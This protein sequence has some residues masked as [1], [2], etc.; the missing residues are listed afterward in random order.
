LASS[1]ILS[2]RALTWLLAVGFGLSSCGGKTS[3]PSP[4]NSCNDNG[5]IHSN[6][7]SWTCS[8]SCD[9]CSCKAGRIDRA[10][11]ACIP[12]GPEGG[13][14]S[15][16]ESDSNISPEAVAGDDASASEV[17]AS[18]FDSPVLESGTEAGTP[19]AGRCLTASCNGACVDEQTDPDNCG[20]CG[21]MCPAGEI[22]Q[23][24]TCGN[25]PSCAPGGLGMTNC[26][27]GTQSCCASL[28]VPGGTYYR[29]YDEVFDAGRT[30]YSTAADGGPVDEADLATISGFRL[31][32]YEV[33]VGRFRQFVGAWS[34]G[35][36]PA[37]GS[38]KHAYLSGGQGLV[39]IGNDAAATYEPGWLVEDNSSIAPTDNN[40]TCDSS[41]TW[42]SP[43]GINEN[44]PINCV[45]WFEAYA[46][47]IWDGGFLPSGSPRLREGISSESIHG[48]PHPPAP[49]SRPPS[50]TRSTTAITRRAP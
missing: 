17:E 5:V 2:N 50:S 48:A 46:F 21:M 43:D 4:A 38:G 11:S 22:C 14:S 26:G 34:A 30:D 18:T 8:Y 49:W 42:P 10:L 16:A 15:D 12:A 20:T 47:C 29:T 13:A 19:D 40:L 45:T 31:D 44:L 7:A 25:P 32:K 23:S 41:A 6:G 27:D 24:G 36:L 33:T 37:A 39:N 35:W 1:L 3:G 9:T 28:E